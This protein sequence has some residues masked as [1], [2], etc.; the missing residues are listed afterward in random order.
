MD[1]K[2]KSGESISMIHTRKY[3][4]K[5]KYANTRKPV[6]IVVVEYR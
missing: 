6:L 3:A 4:Y 5:Y 2:K 1:M